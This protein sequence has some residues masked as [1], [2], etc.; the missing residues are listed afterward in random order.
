MKR[1]HRLFGAVLALGAAAALTLTACSSSE[2]STPAPTTSDP[3][4]TQLLNTAA[5]QTAALT[6][7]HVTMKVDGPAYQGLNATA[8]TADVNTKPAVSGKGTATLNMGGKSVDAP[9]VYVDDS[10]YANIDGQGWINYGDGR[11]IYDVSQI[12]NPDKGVPHILRSLQGAKVDGAEQIDGAATTKVTGT[13]PA[14]E[15][16]ALTG[17]TGQNDSDKSLD[18]TVWIT[19][20]GQVARVAVQPDDKV[21]LT[22]DISGW[23]SSVEVSKPAGVQTPTAKPSAPPASGEPTREKAA[24]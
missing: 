12:L 10:F 17:A 11:S 18:A 5:D 22:V 6:G 20:D 7:A 13:V 15:V 14:K 3:A 23:N 4:A 2:D 9:F 24:G 8:V 19:D 21:T 1:S 16:S